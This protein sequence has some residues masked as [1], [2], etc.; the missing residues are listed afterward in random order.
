VASNHEE[1]NH[2]FGLPR[3][4]GPRS[5]RGEEEQHVMG[6]PVSWFKNANPGQSRR[7][8]NPVRAFKQWRQHRRMGPYAP[9]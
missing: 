2:V 5:R 7:P 6:L 3:G 9:D 8:T 4:M 1:Q